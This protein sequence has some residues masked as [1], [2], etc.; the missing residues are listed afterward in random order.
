MIL[1]LFTLPNHLADVKLLLKCCNQDYFD[2]IDTPMDFGTICSNLESGNKYMNSKEVYKDVQYIWD[3]C[4]K[5]NNKGDYIL[6]LMKRV[7]K[8]FAKYWA[9]AGLLGDNLE[10]TSGKCCVFDPQSLVFVALHVLF[11]QMNY[12]LP[13]RFPFILFGSEEHTRILELIHKFKEIL[14]LTSDHLKGNVFLL[15]SHLFWPFDI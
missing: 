13:F 12:P 14:E 1:D 6:E 8:N 3:N 11:V 7:K 9:A 5:Y 15:S 10:G 2:V 4:Y